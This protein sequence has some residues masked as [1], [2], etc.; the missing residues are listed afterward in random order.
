MKLK[1]INTVAVIGAGDMGHGI[2]ECC[3]IAGYDV[4]LHDIDVDV[5]K[6]AEKRIRDS[7]LILSRKRRIDAR[8]IDLISKRIITSTDFKDS[9][10]LAEV[11]I[12]AVPEIMALKKR[13][14]KELSEL[15]S[16]SSML[17]SN[18][19]NMS[20][21]EIGREAKGKERILGMHFFNPVVLM[22]AVE[23]APSRQTS[24]DYLKLAS[25]FAYTIDHFPVTLTRE[26][27]GFI[28][29]RVQ[30][31]GQVLLNKVIEFGVATFNQIDALALKMHQPMGPFEIMDYVGLDVVKHSLDYFHET[32]GEDFKCGD[33]L[34]DLVKKGHLGKKTGKGVHDWSSG[35]PKIDLNDVTD[36]ITLK[37]L[38]YVQINEACKLIKEGIVDDPDEIE[39][40]IVN[41]TGNKFGI[42]SLLNS[43][44][45]LIIKRLDALSR[46]FNVKAFSPVGLIATLKVPSARRALRKKK[47]R[48][49]ELIA[50]D[51]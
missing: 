11:V 35:R 22:K 19:S 39:F 3:A 24:F 40:A 47:K 46:R 30:A 41:G 31:A 37:D 33:W 29:N 25:D 16:S 43:E 10:S 6:K 15:V 14:F 4:F 2:A 49:K 38:L 26:S 42:F 5:L 48:L 20:I 32:L 17:L 44:R 34:R 27:P 21:T 1:N 18:T 28:V 51:E 13:I 45:E 36:Q 9:C 12:E 7:L 23:I 50:N 8:D